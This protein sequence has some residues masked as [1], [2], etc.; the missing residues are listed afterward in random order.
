MPNVN[1]NSD[2]DDACACRLEH[3]EAE[4]SAIPLANSASDE[5]FRSR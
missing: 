3:V 5:S 2:D 4:P 1:M